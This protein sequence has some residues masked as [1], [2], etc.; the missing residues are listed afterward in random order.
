MKT[1]LI[2]DDHISIFITAQ[3]LRL[4]NFSEDIQTFHSA[5]DALDKLVGATGIKESPQVI[6]LDLN[7]PGMNGWE[8]LDTIKPYENQLLNTCRIY[9]LTSSLDFTDTKRIKDYPLVADLLHKPIGPEDIQVIMAEH[10][11]GYRK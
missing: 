6:F 10:A 7:M 9:I 1:Y 8:F 4:E 3:T 5:E 2:D 11:E